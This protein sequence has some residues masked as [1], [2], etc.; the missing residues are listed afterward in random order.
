MASILRRIHL[1]R[2]LREE[3]AGGLLTDHHRVGFLA[4]R[5]LHNF[6]DSGRLLCLVLI[7]SVL[8]G[9]AAWAFLSSLSFVTHVREGQ[10]A[11]FL[12]LPV[13][14]VLTVWL[15]RTYGG[16]ATKGNNLVIESA[17]TGLLIKAR[18]AILT[19][20]CSVATHLAGGSAGRE[21]TAVQIGGTIASNVSGL[22]KLKTYDHRDL[23]LAGISA[24]F[25]AVFGTPLA[26]AFFGMEMC[27]VGKLEYGVALY[28]LVASFTG[29]AVAR[30]L[31]AHHGVNLITA[32]PALSIK[33][34]GLS[35]VAA[36]IFGW[37]ARLFTALIRTIKQLYAR[38]A[39]HYIVPIL[40]GSIVLTLLFLFTGARHYAGLS[41]WMVPAAF[42]GKTSLIDVASK[43]ILTCL[44]LGTGFQGGE[45]T[46]L[47]GIGAAL[48]GWLGTLVGLDPTLPAALGM[49]AVFGSALNVP[50]TTIMLAIDLFGGVGMHYFV[51]VVFVSYFITGHHGVYTAQRIMSPK[52]RSLTP[53]ARHTVAE[54]IAHVEEMNPV[55]TKSE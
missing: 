30:F 54:A 22:A 28:C 13:V 40:A 32:V 29:D 23:V 53:D 5:D 44:T 31:G 7:V 8:M 39:G 10:P 24:A 36:I 42:A 9:V 38:W 3:I 45:V 4:R 11:L 50:V 21:G 27:F 35:L 55:D 41:E 2:R 20:T 19:F 33:T 18:M 15:Y 17:G 6:R 12:L 48:G 26:G 52:R 25:G 37:I 51:I 16:R 34:L 47:F 43:L 14:G 1:A 46:P 49:L